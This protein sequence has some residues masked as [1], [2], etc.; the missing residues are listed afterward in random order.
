M[1]TAPPDDSSTT[2][3]SNVDATPVPSQ[4]PE[5]DGVTAVGADGSTF[6]IALAGTIAAAQ[7]SDV[8]V[9]PSENDQTTV[10][11]LTV[12][13]NSGL[14]FSNMTIPKS[15]IGFGNVPVVYIDGSQAV[16]QGYTEDANNFYVWY[17]T[18]FS[19]HDI[20]VV[21][22]GASNDS[23]DSGSVSEFPWA[24]VVGIVVALV[25][26]VGLVLVVLSKRKK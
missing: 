16:D 19:T 18:H 13:G 3:S 6:T 8:T 23:S 17:A 24:L 21:F 11:S 10:V 5:G 25:V 2:W 20:T 15:A 12:T 14:G 26:V 22:S 7:I 9:I 4:A 1:P